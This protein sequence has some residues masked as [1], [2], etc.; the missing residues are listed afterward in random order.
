[1]AATNKNQVDVKIGQVKSI[2]GIEPGD[3]IK[4]DDK[5]GAFLGEWS[6]W[7]FFALDPEGPR[8]RKV[9]EGHFRERMSFGQIEKL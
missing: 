9:Y 5:E 2:R 7:A 4:V 1:M 6:G 3:R 8:T